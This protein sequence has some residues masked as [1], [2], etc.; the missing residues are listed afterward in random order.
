[1]TL[2]QYLK[3]KRLEKNIST[4]KLAKDL[5]INYQMIQKWEKNISIP[6]AKNI[7]LLI[8]YLNLN[9]L[10]VKKILYQDL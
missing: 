3:E 9:I 10:E 8:D 6:N 7:F 4:Y 1:M 2:G 5:K